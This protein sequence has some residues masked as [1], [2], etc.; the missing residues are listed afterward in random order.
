[1]DYEEEID[2]AWWK[3]CKIADVAQAQYVAKSTVPT[4]HLVVAESVRELMM[5]AVK[6]CS[7][8]WN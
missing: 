4:V 5:R 7:M 8:Y 3:S 6:A 2:V 1:M